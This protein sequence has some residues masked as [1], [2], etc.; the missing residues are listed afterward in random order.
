MDYQGPTRVSMP[1]LNYDDLDEPIV[2]K[3]YKK[4]DVPEVNHEQSLKYTH[5]YLK[6]LQAENKSSNMLVQKY[7]EEEQQVIEIEEDA[8]NKEIITIEEE[9]D[10]E[11]QKERSRK[12]IEQKQQSRKE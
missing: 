5:D 2:V 12:I 7:I 11:Q 6:E 10:D 3:K 1:S 8:D 4:M 9:S